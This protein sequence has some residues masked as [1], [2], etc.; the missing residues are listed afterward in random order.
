[1]EVHDIEDCC[2]SK[3]GMLLLDIVSTLF[4]ENARVQSLAEMVV[5]FL[6]WAT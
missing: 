6:G 3:M 2:C 1:M 5:A 4:C